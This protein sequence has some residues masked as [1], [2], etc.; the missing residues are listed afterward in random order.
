MR[1]F[2]LIVCCLLA[3]HAVA[4]TYSLQQCIDT[5]IANNISLL[6]QKNTYATSSI[7]YKQSLTNL[8]PSLSAGVGQNWMFYRCG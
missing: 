1:K 4:E 3:V 5:A 8:S 2:S 7:Q 6:V